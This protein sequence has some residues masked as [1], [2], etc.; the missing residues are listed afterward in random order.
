MPS[1]SSLIVFDLEYTAWECSMAGRWLKP[2]EFKEVVQ[3]GALRLSGIDF[4]VLDEFEVLVRPRINSSLSAYFENLTGLTNR[5]LA[6]RSVDFPEAYA[7][8]LAFAGNSP[9][10]SF[11]R[12]DQVLEDNIRLYGLKGLARL[13]RFEDLRPW[14]AEQ[15]LDPRGLDSCDIGLRLGIRPAGRRH[16]ALDDC[17]TLAGVMA[18]M[19]A[20]VAAE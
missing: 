4:T 19:A 17:R 3:I 11:G 10:S 6:E 15:G 1:L 18:R 12:D 9:V 7:R 16:N 13:S 5:M 8:F 14:F 2:G 20:P